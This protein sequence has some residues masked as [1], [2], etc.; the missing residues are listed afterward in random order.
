MKCWITEKIVHLGIKTRHKYTG[1]YCVYGVVT[2]ATHAEEYLARIL[3]EEGKTENT[4]W[5]ESLEEAK[6]HI[7]SVC[8]FRYYKPL[9]LKDISLYY[10]SKLYFY[11]RRL[12][13]IEI[14]KN[15]DDFLRRYDARLS[16]AKSIF[17]KSL[18]QIPKGDKRLNYLSISKFNERNDRYTIKRIKTRSTQE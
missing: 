3:D 12:R 5:F 2:H 9:I 10:N 13:L 14:F 18:R 16:Y 15:I 7:E 1:A 17:V 6:A 4:Q 11:D 8:K